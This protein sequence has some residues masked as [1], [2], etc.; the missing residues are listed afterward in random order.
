V[1]AEAPPAPKAKRKPEATRSSWSPVDLGPI[2]AGKY[3]V[4]APSLLVRTDGEALVYRRRLHSISAEPEGGKGWL[5][6]HI[7]AE[8]IGTGDNV[9]MLDFEVEAA[10][11]V[12]RLRALGVEDDAIGEHFHYVR[13]DEPLTDSG[14]MALESIVSKPLALVILDGVTEAMTL[15]GLNPLDNFDVAKWQILPKRIMDRTGAAVVLV[16]HVTKNREDRGRWSIGAQHKMA[17]ISVAYTLNVVESFGRGKDGEVTISV[18]KDR[19]GHVRRLAEEKTVATMRLLSEEEGQ[20]VRVEIE[21]P[22]ERGEFRPTVLMERLS[23]Q[24]ETDPGI[25]KR[26]LRSAV[27]GKSEAKDLALRLLIAE[28]YVSVA[29]EGQKVAH[30]PVKLYRQAEDPVLT[31]ASNA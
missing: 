10:E 2:L 27:K 7:A 28:D 9:L 4:E 30:H 23:E 11:A 8:V 17:G 29:R 26:E 6:L 15:D 18:E 25:G 5:T 20:R 24:I 3:N 13:P 22:A 12:D 31:G 19:P 14:W 16:D 1:R 21:P